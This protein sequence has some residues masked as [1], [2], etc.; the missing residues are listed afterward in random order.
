[1]HRPKRSNAD[2]SRGTLS[3]KPDAA[4]VVRFSESKTSKNNRV[5]HDVEVL[6][7]ELELFI[8]Y[9]GDDQKFPVSL[10]M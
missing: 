4:Y 3:V 7:Y 1:M 2:A 9:G 10:V 8:Q 5:Y 6:G